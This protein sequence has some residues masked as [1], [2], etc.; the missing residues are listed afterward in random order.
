MILVLTVFIQIVLEQD[1]GL[2]L[3]WVQVMRDSFNELNSGTALVLLLG[4]DGK[5]QMTTVTGQYCI[6][7]CK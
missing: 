2:N 5:L 7:V 3:I 1:L 4:G 6:K